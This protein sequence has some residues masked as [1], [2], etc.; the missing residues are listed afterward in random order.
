MSVQSLDPITFDAVNPVTTIARIPLG[1]DGQ[2]DE[3][4]ISN[5]TPFGIKVGIGRHTYWLDPF[6]VD[7]YQLDKLQVMLTPVILGGTPPAVPFTPYVII[8]VNQLGDPPIPGTY[9]T[10]VPRLQSA[11]NN[12]QALPGSPFSIARDGVAHD[13]GVFTLPPGTLGLAFVTK[14]PADINGLVVTGQTTQAPYGSPLSNNG[15]GTRSLL[16]VRVHPRIDPTVDIV[17]QTPFGAGNA[18][19]GIAFISDASIVDIDAVTTT[20][21]VLVDA[22]GNG[23]AVEGGSSG[24]NRLGVSQQ[25]ANSAVWESALANPVYVA[26]TSIASGGTLT[27][28]AGTGGQTVRVHSCTFYQG[29]ENAAGRFILQDTTGAGVEDMFVNST[30]GLIAASSY[31][32][33]PLPLGRGLQVTNQG[34]LASFFGGGIRHSK[35]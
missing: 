13:L 31:Q 11:Y 16:Y 20:A 6:V 26:A 9:P 12:E 25:F 23:L 29:G 33:A 14:T 34:G 18:L 3:I 19:V 7:K 15:V 32:A 10:A 4:V 2:G 5:E 21:T 28:I 8:T 24:G 17:L 22:S 35:A 30:R 27:L 1:N